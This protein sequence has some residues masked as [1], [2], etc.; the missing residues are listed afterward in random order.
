MLVAGLTGAAESLSRELD[1]IGRHTLG[2]EH[3][4]AL[5]MGHLYVQ[6]LREHGRFADAAPRAIEAEALWRGHVEALW[7]RPG[8]GR[9]LQ[10]ERHDAAVQL[11]IT[12]T[13]ALSLVAPSASQEA[14]QWKVKVGSRLTRWL[15]RGARL[16]AGEL[17]AAP[18]SL[19]QAMALAARRALDA[20]G[21][22][23]SL[24]VSSPPNSL[25]SSEAADSEAEDNVAALGEEA[26]AAWAAVVG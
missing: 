26:A 16:P 3:P 25:A 22:Y 20:A 1:A 24:C 21:G 14:L 11:F 8:S 12:T 9:A 15:H 7:A 6:A 19:G 5:H 4:C 18:A 13:T 2:A 17:D 23:G 10:E